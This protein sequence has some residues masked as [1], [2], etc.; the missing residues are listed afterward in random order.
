M[1]NKTKKAGIN[2]N[3]T[4]RKI[5]ETR[6]EWSKESALEKQTEGLDKEQAEK[7]AGKKDKMAECGCKYF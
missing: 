2:N 1:N 6:K 5:A 3:D 7:T 4:E